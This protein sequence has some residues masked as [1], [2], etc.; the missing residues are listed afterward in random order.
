MF[1]FKRARSLVVNDLH[2]ETRRSWFES[3]CYNHFHNILRDFD[4]LLNFSFTASE[5]MRDYYLQTWY[6]PV[7]SQVAQRLKKK[8]KNLRKKKDLGS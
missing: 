8:K 1:S 3:G 6:I 5:T 7:A 4:V 2:S